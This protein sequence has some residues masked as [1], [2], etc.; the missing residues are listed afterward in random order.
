MTPAQEAKEYAAQNGFS[1]GAV[2][3]AKRYFIYRTRN[4]VSHGD[5]IAEVGGY[6]AAL[7]AMKRYVQE[8]AE[9]AALEQARETGKVGALVGDVNATNVEIMDSGRMV[10]DFPFEDEASKA[11]IRAEARRIH[12][13]EPGSPEWYARNPWRI[14]GPGYFPMA[15]ATRADA[16]KTVRRAYAGEPGI[17]IVYVGV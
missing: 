16:L 9:S 8:Q 4:G 3:G 5:A 1:I 15:Y 10:A 11:R 17:S 7:N 2:V 6:P 13:P 12:K 14:V